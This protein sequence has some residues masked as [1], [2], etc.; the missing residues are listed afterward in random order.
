MDVPSAHPRRRVGYLQLSRRKPWIALLVL[1]AMAGLIGLAWYLV[2]SSKHA[3]GPGA[4]GRRGGRPPT[5]VSMAA[6][7]LAD[8]PVTLDALGTVTPAATVTV[9][10]QVSGVITQILYREGQLVRRGQALAVI[11][12]RPLQM[13]LLQSQGQLTRDQAQ[14]ANAELT[15]TRYRT[16]LA[17]DS[18]AATGRV[19]LAAFCSTS[20]AWSCGTV[21]CTSIGSISV[22]TTRPVESPAPM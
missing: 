21:N 10:P 12:P 4:F 16:L 1:L 20:G 14:L 7:Q 9:R 11:D 6:A 5:T 18:I 15:L 8:V 17:Q 2:S 22:S 19:A 13:A 3:S